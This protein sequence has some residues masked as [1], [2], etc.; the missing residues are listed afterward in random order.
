MSMES[1]KAFVERIK[2]DQE[3]AANMKQC[4][5]LEEFNK[6]ITNAGFNF[7]QEEVSMVNNILEDDQL[8]A[9]LGG[10]GGVGIN[11]MLDVVVAG[12]KRG[13]HIA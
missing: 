9:V 8:E 10:F 6:C 3:F 2:T 4:K 5:N 7:T 1:A 11:P 13:G 12:I